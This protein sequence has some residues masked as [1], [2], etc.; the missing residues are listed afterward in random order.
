MPPAARRKRQNPARFRD[1]VESVRPSSLHG[2]TSLNEPVVLAENGT[3]VKSSTEPKDD[4][5]WVQCDRCGKW[6]A[7]PSTVDANALPDI[8]DCTMNTFDVEKNNCD[9]PEDSSATESAGGGENP[10]LRSFFRFVSHCVNF[11]LNMPIPS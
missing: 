8:W 2:G 4:R 1:D 7:L 5:V 10:N 9:A 11:N 3:E 6:R